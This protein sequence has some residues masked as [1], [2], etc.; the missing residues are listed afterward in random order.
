MLVCFFPSN[1]QNSRATT[2]HGS[3]LPTMG[4]ELNERAADLSWQSQNETKLPLIPTYQGKREPRRTIMLTI[5][6]M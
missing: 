4:E 6:S 1:K 5:A 3:K 2:T